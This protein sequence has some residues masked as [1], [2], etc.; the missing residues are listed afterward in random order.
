MISNNPAPMLQYEICSPS[1]RFLKF[2]SLL[3]RKEKKFTILVLIARSRELK[4][5]VEGKEGK[6]KNV[7][8]PGNR[9]APACWSNALPYFQ[10]SFQ[11]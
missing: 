11:S 6:Y 9:R 3:P 7:I 5:I 2:A 1:V 8:G 4:L 10:L